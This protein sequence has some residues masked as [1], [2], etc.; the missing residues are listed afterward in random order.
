[1]KLA[2]AALFELVGS[3]TA[4]DPMSVSVTA[5]PD[6]VPEFTFTT[7][8]KLAVAFAAKEEIEQVTVPV[9]F[10]AGVVHVQGPGWVK[11]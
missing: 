2:V 11:D 8:L 9:P 10:T 3:V 5:V 4:D 6:V 7:R 1:M